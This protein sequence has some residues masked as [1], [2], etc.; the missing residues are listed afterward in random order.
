MAVAAIKWTVSKW[1]RKPLQAEIR[2]LRDA[3]THAHLDRLLGAAT[4][5]GA[6]ASAGAAEACGGRGNDA[7]RHSCHGHMGD[8]A[9]GDD[10]DGMEPNWWAVQTARLRVHEQAVLHG[11]L[12]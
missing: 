9:G 10:G 2:W 1:Y 7:G 12:N 3:T 4:P 6:A 5:A 8:A 11:W